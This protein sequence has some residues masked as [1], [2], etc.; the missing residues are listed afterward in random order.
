MASIINPLDTLS[1]RNDSDR[2]KLQGLESKL[3]ALK[4]KKGNTDEDLWQVAEGFEEIF[5]N[6]MMKSMDTPTL[7]EGGI[8]DNS[9][10]SKLYKEMFHGE[11]TH[12]MSK[13]REFGLSGMIFDYLKGNH[14]VTEAY[15]L[16]DLRGV[17]RP[18]LRR[19]MLS[20]PVDGRLTS[21][22]GLRKHP[23]TG[24]VHFHQGIDIA[25]SQ[26]TPI[27]AVKDGTV[28]FSG[29][30]SG[31]GKVVILRHQNGLSTLYAHSSK[32]AVKAG[33]QVR[34]GQVVGAV[35]STGRSTG[36]HLHFEV[37]RD[38]KAVN[39]LMYLRDIN[40]R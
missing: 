16:R 11:L 27:R 25:A 30:M 24:E 38:G 32:L 18:V 3:Q 9:S 20:S 40:I 21:G 13:R 34:Q 17:D 23:I 6:I 7:A 35:G 8:L 28:E 14:G 12:V 4:T 39:P 15:G 26:G 19:P 37:R 1:I 22:F 36:P 5:L 33:D 2:N 29:T 10:E 31:Y